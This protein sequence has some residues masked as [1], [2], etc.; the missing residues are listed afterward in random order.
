MFLEDGLCICNF[1]RE[2][3]VKPNGGLLDEIHDVVVALG[4]R[5]R[6][7]KNKAECS[8]GFAAIGVPSS[9]NRPGTSPVLLDG[10]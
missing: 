1:V 10:P 5:G 9:P 7:L 2:E 8:S 3:M 4:H 6:R